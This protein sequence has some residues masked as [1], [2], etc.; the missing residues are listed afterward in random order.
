MITI[1]LRE[2]W[3]HRN[4]NFHRSEKKDFRAE[5]QQTFSNDD[6]EMFFLLHVNSDKFFSVHCEIIA[7]ML[8]RARSIV[9][10]N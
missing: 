9:L 8:M 5:C 4:R 3:Q 10:C 2:T 1:F 6:T 7:F